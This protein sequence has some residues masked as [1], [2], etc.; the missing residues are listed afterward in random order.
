MKRRLFLLAVATVLAACATPP[1]TPEALP[2]RTSLRDF[3]LDGRF[4]LRIERL[5]E[6][7]QSAN[8]R[9]SWAHQN[10]MDRV[11][12]ANP[13]GTG[14][15]EIDIGPPLAR[16]RLATGERR[17]HP[18]ADLLM[19]EVTGYA[20]PVTRLAGWLLGRAGPDGDLV[21][22]PFGRPSHLREAGWQIDYAYADELPGALPWRLD[23]RRADEVALILRIDEWREAP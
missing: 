10:G 23:I 20:L 21:S 1:R 13:L 18:D 17:E 9:L 7:V 16:L 22:D 6:P 14:F 15:A 11:L 4:A 12:L 3:A 8:G 5:G 19:Q 2:G